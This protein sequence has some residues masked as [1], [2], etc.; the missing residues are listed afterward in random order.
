[1]V[2]LACPASSFFQPS[3]LLLLLHSGKFPCPSGPKPFVTSQR[4]LPEMG[5]LLAGKVTVEEMGVWLQLYPLSSSM[6]FPIGTAQP[7]SDPSRFEQLPLVHLVLLDVGCSSW[8]RK[9]KF[10]SDSAPQPLLFASV[11]PFL[12]VSGPG[13]TQYSAVKAAEG[14]EEMKAAE[15]EGLNGEWGLPK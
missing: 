10:P 2:L 13:W 11:S 6:P 7:C 4:P 12:S 5:G 8:G 1:M 14:N 9:T 3:L 15:D